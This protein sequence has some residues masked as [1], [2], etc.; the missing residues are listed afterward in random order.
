[1]IASVLLVHGA[2][3][4]PWIWDGWEGALGGARVRALDLQSGVRVGEATMDDYAD[5]VV[6]AARGM[7]APRAIVGWSMGGLAAMMAARE[8]GPARLVLLEPTPSA[9]I[10]GAAN[11]DGHGPLPDGTYDPE[12]AYGAFPA[13]M[14]ARPESARAL[15]QCRRGVSV[16]ELRGDVLV[17]HGDEHAD[18]SGRALA[19][20]YGV[21]TLH[22]PGRDHWG[23]VRDRA[24]IDAVAAEILRP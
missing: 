16:P 12:Q 2:G 4:G 7:R 20:H 10:L 24:A 15:E 14:R 8:S 21:R 17:V 6:R 23:I 3:S 1:M 11:G 9:E 22:L 18:A 19:A 5:A 13:D